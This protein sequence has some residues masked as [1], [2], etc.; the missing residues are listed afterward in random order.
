L[1]QE[2]AYPQKTWKIL[3]SAIILEKNILLM[4]RV[5]NTRKGNVKVTDCDTK[6]RGRTR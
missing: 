4:D 3:K 5:V 6:T 2:R 1:Q